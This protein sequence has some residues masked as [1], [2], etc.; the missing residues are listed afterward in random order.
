MIQFS[1]SLNINKNI[2]NVFDFLGRLENF[3]TWNYA[4]ESISRAH[5]SEG[6]VGSRYILKRNQGMQGL[7]EITVEEFI[8]LSKLSFVARGNYF[9]YKMMYELTPKGGD[10]TLLT[11]KAEL[12]PLG[13]SNMIFN[14]MQNKIKSEVKGN[15]LVLKDTLESNREL[16]MV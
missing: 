10:V 8:P 7:E 14:I 12:T 4:V 15:L 13:A 5:S 9:S 16:F 3:S 11:N 2:Q 1:N 6:V